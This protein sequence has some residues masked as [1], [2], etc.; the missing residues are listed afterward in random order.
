MAEASYTSKIKYNIDDL[1]SSLVACKTQA[2]QVDGV[3]A[4]I[5]KRGNLNNFIKQFVAMDDAVKALRKDL[6]SVKA[7][8]ADKLNSG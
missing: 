4:N 8:L 3:L 6:D 7:G 1:M 5:G 2:E